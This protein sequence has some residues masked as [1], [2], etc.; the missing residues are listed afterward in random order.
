MSRSRRGRPT[1][2]LRE[3]LGKAASSEVSP[4][5]PGR[6]GRVTVIS[7]FALRRR[8]I[9]VLEGI[10]AALLVSSY[11]LAYDPSPTTPYTFGLVNPPISQDRVGDGFWHDS[12]CTE[13]GPPLYFC[14][15]PPC[16]V[17]VTGDSSVVPAIT[18]PIASLNGNQL[19]VEYFLRNAYC[20]PPADGGDPHVPN[21]IPY[22]IQIVSIAS[23]GSRNAVMTFDPYWE[24]GKASNIVTVD[25]NHCYQAIY[26]LSTGFPV[27]ITAVSSN[28]VGLSTSPCPPDLQICP[29]SAGNPINVGSGNMRYE[30]PLFSIAENVSPMRFSLSYNSQD[31]TPGPLGYGFTHTFSQTLSF[32]SGDGKLLIWTNPKGEQWLFYAGGNPGDNPYSAIWPGEARGTVVYSSGTSQFTFTDLD[33]TVTKFDSVSGH[34][35]S[36]ADRWGNTTTGTY[37]SGNL[38]TIT[39]P[40]GRA[41]TLTYSGTFL[42]T[43]TDPSSH[44]WRFTVDGTSHLTTVFDP[45]HTGATPWRTYTYVT[46]KVGDPTVLASVADESGAVL[47]GHEYDSQGRA[48]SD[49][50]GDTTVTSGVPHPGPNARSKVTMTF[51]TATQTTVTTQVDS[52]SNLTS[53]FTL[54]Y[55]SGRFLPTSIIGNCPSCSGGGDDA[56]TYTY[57]SDN[58]TLTKIVGTGT[59][60]AETDFTYDYNGMLTQMVEAVGKT[61]TRTT[62]YTYAVGTPAGFL[63]PWPSFRTSMTEPSAAQSGS[64]KVTSYSFSTGPCTSTPAETCLATSISGFLKSADA[65]PTVYTTTTLYDGKHRATEIDGPTATNRTTLS[66]YSDTDATTIR[67]GRLQTSSLY[68]S[69]LLHLDTTYDN[70]DIFGTAKKVLDPNAVETDRITDAK[71]RV[72]SETSLHVTGDPNESQDY[73]TAYVFDTRDRFQQKSLPLGNAQKYL[74]ET[75]TN[76]LTDTLRL[77]AAGKEQERRHLTLNVIGNKTKEESQVCTA[78]T[79]NTCTT[80]S[81]KQTE[82]F[83]YDTHGRLSTVTHGDSTLV[84][85]LYDSRGNMLSAQDE[86]HSAAN[87]LYTYDFLNRLKTVTQKQTIISGPDVVTQYAYDVHDNLTSVTDPNSNATTYTFDDFRRMQS[88]PTSPVVTGVPTY[89][90]DQAGNLLQS[91]DGNG[92]STARVF[93]WANRL[94]S[95]NSTPNGGGAQEIVTWKY[96]DATAGNYGK[97]RLAKMSDPIAT[98]TYA[99]ERRGLLRREVRTIGSNTYTISYGYNKN[100]DRTSITYP[101]GRVVNYTFDFADRP[102][103]VAGAS[104]PA[105][106][107]VSAATYQPFGPV[108]TESYGNTTT[109][110]MTY[111]TQRYLPAELKLAGSST[112]YDF[113][114]KEDGVGNITSICDANPCATP[115]LHTNDR[116]FTYDDLNRLKT[117]N[118]GSALWTTGTYS[119]DAMGNISPSLTVGSRTVSFTY[120]QS[121]GHQTPRILTASDSTGGVTYDANGNETLVGTGNTFTYGP[122]NFLTKGEGLAY[123]YD[124]RGLRTATYFSGPTVT[125]VSPTFANQKSTN[126]NVTLTIGG[127]GFLAGATVQ[128]AGVTVTVTNVT[129][130]S[131]TATATIPA[132]S[133]SIPSGFRD[134]FVTN[135]TSFQTGMLSNG[136]DVRRFTDA[137]ATDGFAIYEWM[138][139]TQQPDILEGF[140]TNGDTTQVFNENN[141]VLR[142]DMAR[143]LERARLETAETG[144]VS[145]SEHFC[146]VLCSDSDW[147]WV[148]RFFDDGITAGI[149]TGSCPHPPPSTGNLYGPDQSLTRGQMATFI[150]KSLN[151]APVPSAQCDSAHLTFGDVDCSNPFWGFVEK[152][153]QD[154]ITAGCQASP[155]LFCPNSTITRAQM[156][157]FISKGWQYLPPPVPDAFPGRYSLYTPEMNLLAETSLTGAGPHPILYEY[158]WF[159]GHP[160]AQSDGAVLGNQHW[161]FTDHMG[162]TLRQYDSTGTQYWRAEYEPY[163]R[164]FSLQTANQHE[165]L[166]LPG[167][168]AEELNISSDGNGSSKRFYNIFRWYRF[169][170]GRYTQVDR[171]TSL[172]GPPLSYGADNPISFMDS[173]GLLTETC[174]TPIISETKIGKH[175]YLKVDGHSY[176][177]FPEHR[178]RG[179]A[180]RVF[181]RNDNGWGLGIPQTGR[182]DNNS[183]ETC[184]E[185][186]R[187]SCP[188]IDGTQ[189]QCIEQATSIYPR[190]QY[191]GDGP[192]S[193]TYA[194]YVANTCCEGGFP[195]GMGNTPAA[196]FP[197]PPLLPWP[198]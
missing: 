47:E 96:D 176:S 136:F 85:Y 89:A 125:S 81:S 197:V 167:Q 38:T 64:S 57:D 149:G 82:N 198:K 62:A 120:V 156:A 99:Y 105:V 41:W 122:R 22:Y 18:R 30:E 39:D 7:Q 9:R 139:S 103:T 114:Y 184:K 195:Q 15:N 94:E 111:N 160:I 172:G 67:R 115:T 183:V 132:Y 142:R 126:Y 164:I 24:H 143:W 25:A 95:A 170:W 50:A 194:A 174:C 147:G 29:Y 119:Y 42:A 102:I 75:G 1:T 97:G 186:K 36:T 177:L 135:P 28:I 43:L 14:P 10:A 17:G 153:Y 2:S 185:C 98:T 80:W 173:L 72:T 13:S 137:P 187:K 166:R 84:K 109:R 32:F 56:Q 19:S 69:S 178:E 101:S 46:G 129:G 21:S 113:F 44:Q 65:N 68:V 152:I 34:W 11:A 117:A 134:V 70:Y 151:Q 45:I 128:I 133:A 112:L 54:I 161:N 175:C 79:V 138:A 169:N 66:Y 140:T 191:H 148:Q 83:A 165:P 35:I 3:E 76:R 4:S 157:V 93:D 59:Q 144:C 106:T 92:A 168:E 16:P 8:G 78:W 63:A 5:V 27:V 193:N 163:G 77:D 188:N 60:Q 146:D 181:L 192:N 127:T 107:Y 86:R 20:N 51:D 53:I 104:S 130:T 100:G 116:T 118:T 58:H 141:P 26:V 49:W 158:I 179:V 87:T 31:K 196:N 88:Q 48:F 110:T 61:E 162:T 190:V 182:D 37:T 74:Y 33:G 90:Y 155:P 180:A 55:Q 52:S 91:V 108:A 12:A 154:G 145:G 40:E 123:E 159:N 121:G 71:G 171:F 124:G 150:V 73:T 6:K 189:R 131:I 23:D